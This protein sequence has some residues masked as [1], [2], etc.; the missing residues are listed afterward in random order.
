M[1]A[2]ASDGAVEPSKSQ[3]M[4][5]EGQREEDDEENDFRGCGELRALIRHDSSNKNSVFPWEKASLVLT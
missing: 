4:Q 3:G 2:P 5:S 1:S